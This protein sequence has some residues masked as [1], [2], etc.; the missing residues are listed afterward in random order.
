DADRLFFVQADI[1]RFLPSREKV[2][3]ALYDEDLSLPFAIFN[4]YEQRVAE[5]TAYAREQLKKGFD[6]SKDESYQYQ[7]EKTPWAKSEDELND[8][9]R[10]RVK[11]D[12]L[13]LKLAGKEE[14]KIRETLDKR[15]AN[16]LD[17]MHQLNGED[18]FQTF[19]NAYAMAIEPHTN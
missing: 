4:L 14:A 7:R 6:F 17:R 10:K 5:R 1:D 11:N 19:M 2:G 9:W 8:I 13:R 12:W 15:Y 18:V 16:Y 3:N